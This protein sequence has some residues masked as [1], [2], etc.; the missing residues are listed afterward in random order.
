[1]LKYEE[2]LHDLSMFALYYMPIEQYYIERLRD[3]FIQKLK[4]RLVALQF[5]TGKELIKV[6]QALKASMGEGQQDQSRFGKNKDSIF[7]Q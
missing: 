2:R 3:G 7:P 4:H 6:T 1:M 5:R